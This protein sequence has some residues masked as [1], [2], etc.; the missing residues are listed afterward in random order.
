MS[1]TPDDMTA[2]RPGLSWKRGT[3]AAVLVL[4]I[5]GFYALGLQQYLSWDYIH[6]NVERWQA[7][8]RQNLLA[9]V[10]I[11]F[12]VYVAV[13]ALS[14]PAATALS[15]LAGALFGRWLGTAVVS[16]A[17]TLGA[18]LAFLSSR[19]LFRDLVQRRWGDRLRP[20]NE[21][22]QKDGAYYLFLLRLVPLFPFFLINL[23]MGLTPMRV[24]TFAWVSWLGMLPGTFLYLHTGD[25]L[26]SLDSPREVFSPGV[27]ISLALLGI[28]PLAL[29]QLIRWRNRT[30]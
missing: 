24:R 15:L 16:A 8:V 7:Q 2:S 12:V 26:S 11:F 25:L 1:A 13:T 27:L 28:V 19:Y 3:L 22:I 4:G 5:V 17:A 21:G 29:R 20:L 18:T 9:A 14:L 6:G 30:P 23:G 10:V